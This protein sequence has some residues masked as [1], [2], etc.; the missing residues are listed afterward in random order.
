MTAKETFVQKSMKNLEISRE[1]ALALWA[2]DHDKEEVPQEVLTIEEKLAKKAASPINKV[3][4]LK[5]KKKVDEQKVTIISEVLQF[6]ENAHLSTNSVILAP[7]QV[8]TGKFVFQD[9]LGGFYTLAI[10]K[11]KQKPDGYKGT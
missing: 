5:A 10:T 1:E 4:N 6:L 11:N 3:K 2:F 7:E 9:E 8:G